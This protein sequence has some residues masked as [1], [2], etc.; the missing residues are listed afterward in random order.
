VKE[1]FIVAIDDVFP[2][3]LNHRLAARLHPFV[4]KE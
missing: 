2:L 1:E 3:V 4:A